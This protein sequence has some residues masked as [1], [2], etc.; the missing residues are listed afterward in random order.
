M[1]ET[2]EQLPMQAQRIELIG[3]H[4]LLLEKSPL[5]N[6]LQI[7]APDGHVSLTIHVSPAGPV[8]RFEGAGLIVHTSGALAI[9]A[10]QVAIR[11]RDGVAIVSGGDAHISATGDLHTQAR[12]QSI[13]ATSGD[14][15]VKANDDV[16]L[17]GERIRLN[18]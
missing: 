13:S 16:K 18:C 11:G 6:I 4:Q 14:V 9:D 5:E 3:D 8:L 7:V 2:G 15:N 17:K 1:H 12:T 10:Q